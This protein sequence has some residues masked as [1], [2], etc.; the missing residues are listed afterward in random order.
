MYLA[1]LS[2]SQCG[3]SFTRRRRGTAPASAEKGVTA[4]AR[5]VVWRAGGSVGLTG[6]VDVVR[7]GP[8]GR[9]GGEAAR[10]SG[11]CLL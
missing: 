11:V 1:L 2:S 5:L 10:A 3:Q 8:Q 9:A 6:R 4:T 7:A